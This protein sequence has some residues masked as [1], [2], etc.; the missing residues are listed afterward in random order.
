M[1]DGQEVLGAIEVKLL[2]RENMPS[3]RERERRSRTAK[4]ADLLVG[5]MAGVGQGLGSCA[6]YS[7]SPARRLPE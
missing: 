3:D 4:S 7:H 6:C 5:R 2:L 1:R